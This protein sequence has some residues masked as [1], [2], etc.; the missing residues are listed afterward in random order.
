MGLNREFHVHPISHQP[1]VRFSLN[2]TQ[3]LLNE[4]LC[5]THDSA[6]Q[7][8]GQ[9]HISRSLVLPFEFGVCSISPEP[10]KQFSINFTQM[11]ISVRQ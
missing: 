10:F 9:S 8:R 7:T 2:I 6:T 1:F 11:L 5:R 4:L 3:M